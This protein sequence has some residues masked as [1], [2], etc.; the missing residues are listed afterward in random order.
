MWQPCDTFAYDASITFSV[1]GIQ[2]QSSLLDTNKASGP[3]NIHPYILKNCAYEMAPILQ[4]IFTQSLDTDV[5]LAGGQCMPSLQ[6]N[7]Y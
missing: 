3:G 7:S 1:A 6:K 4:V 2:H 5:G